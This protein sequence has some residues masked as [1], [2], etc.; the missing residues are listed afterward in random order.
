MTEPRAVPAA[1]GTEVAI[2]QEPVG[3]LLNFVALAVKDPTIDVAKLD[4]LLKM[5]RE[6]VA[7]DAKAQFNTAFIKLQGRLPRI[8]KNGSLEYPKDPKNP[9]GP[10][11]KISSFMRWEDIDAAIRP[12]LEEEGFA[13]TFNTVPR[14]GEG[15]GL[16]VTA[17]VRH[18]AGHSQDTSL[19]IPLD[20]SGGKNNIQGYGSALKYGQRYTA[21]A[22]LNIVAE[23][24]DDDGASV[25]NEPLDAESVKRLND[26]ISETK[27]DFNA[28]LKFM[29]VAG[30]PE[31][32][33]RDYPTAV[34]ALLAKKAK[35]TA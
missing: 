25:G 18:R 11:R 24:E 23:G 8:K 2:A 26:L 10:K 35:V 7:D 19:P 32:L 34:N 31:I 4:A 28:F 29:G 3:S 33:V 6:I 20:T 13:L 30:L 12:I 15:G 1:E 9:E 21:C 16:I 17:T 5:Q 14:P 22:A 27:S